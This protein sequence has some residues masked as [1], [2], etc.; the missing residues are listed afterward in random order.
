MSERSGD[1]HGAVVVT[2]Q[3]YGDG[4]HMTLDEAIERRRRWAAFWGGGDMLRAFVAVIHRHESQLGE[5]LPPQDRRY[6][7]PQD[8]RYLYTVCQARD[9]A[10]DRQCTARTHE[11]DDVGLL[12]GVPVAMCVRCRGAA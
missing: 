5:Y 2:R 9:P 1:A 10:L 12:N 11:P 7:P 8:R 6:L 3:S 4:R